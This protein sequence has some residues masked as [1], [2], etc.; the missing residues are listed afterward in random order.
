MLACIAIL[1]LG[2]LYIIFQLLRA[3]EVLDYKRLSLQLK[4][5]LLGGLGLLI[6]F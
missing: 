4:F 2:L 6:F 1:L 5:F 3:R